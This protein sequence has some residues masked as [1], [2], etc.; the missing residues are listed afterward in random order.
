MITLPTDQLGGAGVGP[1]SLWAFVSVP[2]ILGTAQFFP[3]FSIKASVSCVYAAFIGMG[4]WYILT[5]AQELHRSL[6]FNVSC[7][8]RDLVSYRI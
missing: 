1:A 6:A 4:T 2:A 5:S 7:L 8:F 3:K